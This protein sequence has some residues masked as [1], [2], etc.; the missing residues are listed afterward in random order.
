[1]IMLTCFSYT[2]NLTLIWRFVLH[3]DR[4]AYIY[5]K[6]NTDMSVNAVVRTQKIFASLLYYAA[7]QNNYFYY[8]CTSSR[9]RFKPK[10]TAP[11]TFL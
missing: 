10:T 3:Y 11:E 6:K 9:S 7:N 4:Y 8:D 5:C 2:K 1:M